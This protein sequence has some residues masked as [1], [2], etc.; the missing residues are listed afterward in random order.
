MQSKQQSFMI[1]LA[2]ECDSPCMGCMP[3]ARHA[4]PENCHCECKAYIA[5]SAKIAKQ[6]KAIMAKIRQ[7]LVNDLHS[8]TYYDKCGKRR[9]RKLV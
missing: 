6:K 7:T 9:K 1:G 8:E 5:W 2:E 3:P 4:V